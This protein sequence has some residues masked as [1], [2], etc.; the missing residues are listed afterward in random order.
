MDVLL[1]RKSHQPIID[2]LLYFSNGDSEERR[3][4]YE[5]LF[6][7]TWDRIPQT[8]CVQIL[9]NLE[10]V[11]C[12]RVDDFWNNSTPA[13][14]LLC[15][16][17]LRCFIIFD[18]FVALLNH[19]TKIHILAHELAHVFYNHPRKGFEKGAG[20]EKLFIEKEAEPQ[21]YDL[22]EVKWKI[23]PHPDDIPQLRGYKKYILNEK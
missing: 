19:E 5:D 13:C 16:I 6:L 22:T 15:K 14:A 21:A 20:L 8:D 18:P 3:K 11:L 4:I 17:S 9:E 10:F 12:K 1:L 2:R 23:F 7:E